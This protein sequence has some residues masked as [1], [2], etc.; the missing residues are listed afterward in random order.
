MSLRTTL[1]NYKYL[2]S[3]ELF[4]LYFKISWKLCKEHQV[5]VTHA[6]FAKFKASLTGSSTTSAEE[7]VK[8][9]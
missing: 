5:D 7:K 1:R 4:T 9:P 3:A 8:Q 6:A 2:T